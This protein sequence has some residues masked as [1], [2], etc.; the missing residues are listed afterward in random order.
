MEII[1]KT[2]DKGY[3]ITQ[4]NNQYFLNLGQIKKGEKQEAI[5]RFS[6]VNAKTFLLESTCGCTTT[7][8]KIISP[9]EV[10]YKVSYNGNTSLPKTLVIVNNN[11]HIE[12]KLNGNRV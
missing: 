11:K 8:K 4:D 10:E 5:I 2:T 3:S 7:D 6:D 1:L 12:L 9:K